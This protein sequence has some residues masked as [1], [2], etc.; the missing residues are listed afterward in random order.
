M[1][2]SS[3]SRF[4]I[5]TKPSEAKSRGKLSKGNPTSVLTHPRGLVTLRYLSSQQDCLWVIHLLIQLSTEHLLSVRSSA[6]H[7]CARTK[8]AQS[9]PTLCNSMDCSPPDS[10]VHGIFQAG[11][12]EW[13]AI[14]FSRGSF[15]PRGR[16]RVFY[17]SCTGRQVLYH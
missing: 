8:F 12:L 6:T 14:P 1:S 7:V 2:Y 11:I 5:S 13:V 15:W 17:V 9:C 3:W 16:I 4:R 10:S